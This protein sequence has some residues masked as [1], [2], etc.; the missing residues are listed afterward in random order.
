M[1]STLI[2]VFLNRPVLEMATATLIIM[3]PSVG[4]MGM[5]ASMVLSQVSNTIIHTAPQQS[6]KGLGM[7]FVM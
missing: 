2:V 5:T 7:E 3:Y 1:L 4:G 6:H